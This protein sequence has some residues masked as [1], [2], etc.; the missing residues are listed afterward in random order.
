M[1]KKMIKY[2][3]ISIVLYNLVMIVPITGFMLPNYKLKNGADFTLKEH[4][5]TNI[6]ILAGTAAI[7]YQN[8]LLYISV[9][10]AIEMIFYIFK[11]VKFKNYHFK[12]FDRI[13]ITS[14][15]STILVVICMRF[16][17]GDIESIKKL[18]E[19]MYINNYGMSESDLKLAFKFIK[20]YRY[21]LIFSYSGLMTYLTYLAR[22]RKFYKSWHMS[23][24]WVIFYIIPF[25]ANKYFN[26]DS[27]LL[28]NILIITKIT[29]IVYAAKILY[30]LIGNKI[31]FDILKHILSIVVVFYFPNTAFV[32]GGLYS[33][34]IIKIKIGVENNK[35]NK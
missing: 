15:I 4:I 33:F 9:F 27:I 30:N 6:V 23:Y 35:E 14:I 32:L 29:Y 22:G 26:V 13:I 31:R 1:N 17:A 10:L 28:K 21:F 16:L 20:D 3:L 11:Y 19:D 24:I 25:L 7:S 18:I 8:V 2:S 34:R 12:I 5:L